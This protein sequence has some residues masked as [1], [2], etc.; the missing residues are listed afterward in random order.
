M[1]IAESFEDVFAK[2]I[3]LG[4]IIGELFE[5]LVMDYLIK[6][7]WPGEKYNAKFLP[8]GQQAPSNQ[9]GAY[10]ISFE[11]ELLASNLTKKKIKNP[12]LLLC[13][14][15]LPKE[16]NSEM[17]LIIKPIDIKVSI[18]S[19]KKEQLSVK[20]L[21]K[22]LTHSK[23]KNFLSQKLNINLDFFNIQIQ[24]G[25]LFISNDYSYE[26]KIF[27]IHNVT[28]LPI[29][30]EQ[31]LQSLY[32][33]LF[34]LATEFLKSQNYEINL[35][36]KL[37][38]ANVIL[39]LVLIIVSRITSYQLDKIKIIKRR[40]TN[41]GS[42]PEDAKNILKEIS[43]R[44]VN[45]LAEKLAN[46]GFEKSLIQ[47]LLQGKG[48]D[49]Y[50]L[51]PD[52]V[53]QYIEFIKKEFEENL[54][55]RFSGQSIKQMI[56]TENLFQF[57]INEYNKFQ[58]ENSHGYFIHYLFHKGSIP[59]LLE[60]QRINTINLNNI[61]QKLKKGQIDAETFL[62][63]Q[64]LISVRPLEIIN[65]TKIS[66]LIKIIQHSIVW[67]QGSG[68]TRNKE[69][70]NILEEMKEAFSVLTNSAEILILKNKKSLLE[71]IPHKEN[72]TTTDPTKVNLKQTQEN[73]TE[74]LPRLQPTIK[75]LESL[76]S[77][78]TQLY[79]TYDRLKKLCGRL[80]ISEPSIEKELRKGIKQ[81]VKSQDKI[82]ANSLRV[83]LNE[84]LQAEV[85][86]RER[87]QQLNNWTREEAIKK[88][89]NKHIKLLDQEILFIFE[90]YRQHLQ[91]A[92]QKYKKHLNNEPEKIS[93][94]IAQLESELTILEKF[95]LNKVELDE[96]A[97]RLLVLTQIAKARKEDDSINKNILFKIIKNPTFSSST[98]NKLRE[99]I[100]EEI[101]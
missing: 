47:L 34:S 15:T 92:I 93:A 22:L 16:G 79:K 9:D 96:E 25:E 95:L 17:F 90:K 81:A 21:E 38:M 71:K 87:I 43:S 68:N 35:N 5:Q 42:L 88:F 67:I 36:N 62:L 3:V 84:I 78:I 41:K 72:F 64:E 57:A 76:T 2:H 94:Y 60:E 23:I 40:I 4:D 63:I 69:L 24:P 101:G 53:N 65:E 1:N 99:L 89:K 82:T 66:H 44:K 91:K 61:I 18:F 32:P 51:D 12:D 50:L 70:R 75:E 80:D 54:N 58:A 77:S 48:E 29:N 55:L 85:Y 20:N 13:E 73:F 97:M 83:L 14:I 49:L 31:E 27:E 56:S 100:L 59:V 46:K 37:R 52:E 98:K 28:T 39:F 86:K 74:I 7:S 19:A 6:N 26:N 33:N 11:E 45:L 10:I 30:L 8:L